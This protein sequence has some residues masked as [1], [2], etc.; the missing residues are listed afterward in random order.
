VI[1]AYGTNGVDRR[2]TVV[3]SD[4]TWLRCLPGGPRAKCR[5]VAGLVGQHRSTQRYRAPPPDFELR[6]VKRMNELAEAHPL[7]C[8]YP[9][10]RPDQGI[11][12]IRRPC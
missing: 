9:D 1:F 7:R 5:R 6:L 12:T 10:S 11:G 2:K 3:T 8:Q 4:R